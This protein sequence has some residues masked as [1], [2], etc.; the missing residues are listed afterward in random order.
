MIKFKKG[1]VI[2]R[3]T[4]AYSPWYKSFCREHGLK[5]DTQFYV[6]GEYRYG[7][8]RIGVVPGKPIGSMEDEWMELVNVSLENK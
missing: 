3:K 2:V 7:A 4:S 6:E 5:L 1:D 8:S